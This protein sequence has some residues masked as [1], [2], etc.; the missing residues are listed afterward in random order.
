MGSQPDRG[1]FC[2]LMLL[3]FLSE[4]HFRWAQAQSCVWYG[5]CAES[6]T[7]AGKKYNCNYTGPPIPLDPEGDDLLK[8]LCPGYDYG[9]RE[10]CCNVDQLR[11]LKGSLQLPL[12]FLSRCP[13]CFFNLMNLFCELTCSPHQSQFL[14][15]TKFKSTNSTEFN[16]SSVVEVQYYIGKAFSNAM[17]NACRDVQAP[18]SNVKALSLLCG[19]DA[20]DCNATN[21]IEYMFDINNG[22]SPFPIIPIFSDVPVSGYTPM[23]NKTYGCS[24]GLEDGSGPCSC[25]DCTTTCGPKPVPPPTPPPWTII[26]I[27]AMTVIMWIFYMAFLFVFVGT[28]LAAWCYRKRTIMSEYGP[29][30]DSNNPLSLNSDN[31]EA[32][33]ASCCETLGERFENMMRVGFSSWGSFCVRY[34]GLVILASLL[35]VVAS[36]G[37]LVYMRIT[38]DPVELWSSPGSQA[39]QEKDYFDSHFGPFYRTAQLIITTPLNETFTY[40]PYFGG[41]SVPFGAILDKDILHQ[42]L[43]LQLAIE[44][45]VA[46]YDGQNIT[47]KDICLAPLAPYNDNCT[48]LSILNY[49]QNSHAVLDH[50][51]GD[52]FFIYADFHSHFL[53]CVSAPASLNDTTLLHDPCLGTFGGPIFP[54]LALGGYDSTNYNNASAL[55]ITFPINNYLNDMARRGKA[56]AWEN[57]FIRFMKEFHNPNLTIA[58]SAERSVEDEINRESNSDIS[59]V[60]LSYA[61]MFVYISLALGHI[62]SCRRLPVD[63]KI[64]LGIAG[65]LIVL[66]SVASSLG[67]FSYFGIPLTLIVIEVIPFLV[68]AVGVDNIFII[69]QTYQRDERMPQE[70]LHQ[71]I[72]RILGDVA[73]SMFLSSFSE[74]V[75]FFLGA[76][77]NMPAVRTFSLFAGLAVFIDFLLQISCFVSLLGLDL[78]RQEANRLDIICCVKLP[79][80]QEAKTDSILFRFFKK[81]Y[82]P[83]ILKE[84][85]RP[86]VVAV[87]VGALSF[88]IAV[89]NKVEIGLDQQLS[90]PDDSYVL[91]YFKNLNQYLHT[92]AP[93]YFVVEDGLNYSSLEGQ[94]AVCGGVGCNNN[95]LVQ[96]IYSASLISN[97]STIAFTPSSWLDDYFD[98]VKPQSTCC[99]YYNATGAFCNASVVDP[100]CVHCRPMTQSGK[101]RPVGGDFM[102]FLPMF[103]SDNPNVKCGK[104]GHAAYA[105]A[106]DVYPNNTQ[107]GAS[108]FMTFHTILKESSDYIDALKMAR[109]LA[110]NI[111][112]TMDHK[113]FAYSVFYVFYEQYLT[114]AYDTAFNLS[115]SLGA[116]FVVTAVLLGF[117]LWSAVLV[118]VTIAMILVNMFGVMWLWNISL[119]A[120]S[121]VNLVMACG[122]SVEFC[123]HLVRAFSISMKK[124]RVARAEE[125]L[126]H[127]GSS[128]FSGITMTKFGG[129][130]ILALS[131]SQI[132]QVFYFRM[133]LAIV[134]LGAAHGLIFLPVLLSYTGPSANR[135]KVFAANRRFVG[136]ERERL[137][138]Y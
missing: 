56:L 34:P 40:D 38:T 118:C 135:A 13:S 72:G 6:E 130:L 10:L 103:L 131:K 123:S 70:E 92:G 117:E 51:L 33:H 17:Y 86:I 1:G 14:N 63:S 116:I 81:F 19:K 97:Y 54:W 132:F 69:V 50:M 57:E 21:W 26:G 107:V 94:N 124:S 89:V 16:S 23:N 110:D 137:L 28:V 59:T 55:V 47:L 29:I 91:E 5:E 62:H 83:F 138:N 48:I 120:V 98:W 18:S 3:I 58:F 44:A 90:M 35:L 76:L 22:Q 79:E 67:I 119:N 66:S 49:F 121:L 115:V 60:V 71:Q 7:V 102:H 24:E 134:L 109:V 80:G 108:Y 37:G 32:V 31:P 106:V 128:V 20:K 42:V 77:S 84:W 133:Y 39:R 104:G 53:Y 136:T 114:I 65:I 78:K 82:A 127:M 15:A 36:S 96:Q 87:F 45:L 129:I 126:A 46:P 9:T 30:L 4:A 93:V 68:L 88:S 27:D 12:Q 43:D 61:I 8:E 95:S 99:R 75:A 2:L 112:Q 125:A 41:S 11:T 74:T 111:S 122:I 52:Q 25:Q 64:S 73:P 105:T 100:S 113:V 101:Q 85:V